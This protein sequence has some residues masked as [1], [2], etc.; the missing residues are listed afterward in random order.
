MGFRLDQLAGLDAGLTRPYP[1]R[2]VG[3]DGM[4][5]I[6][7]EE[8]HEKES[9]TCLEVNLVT[10]VSWIYKI[11]LEIQLPLYGTYNQDTGSLRQFPQCRGLKMPELI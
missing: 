1:H 11:Q 8:V 5:R 7:V 2:P 4:D 3:W 10:G 9:P 6:I